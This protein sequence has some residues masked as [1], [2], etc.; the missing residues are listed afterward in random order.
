M[1]SYNLF[2]SLLVERVKGAWAL[3]SEKRRQEVVANWKA[4]RKVGPQ[5]PRVMEFADLLLE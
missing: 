2:S 5:E 3:A 4:A 1:S